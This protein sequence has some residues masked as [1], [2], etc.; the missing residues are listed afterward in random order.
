MHLLFIVICW[1]SRTCRCYLQVS[2]SACKS[3][4]HRSYRCRQPQQLPFASRE[5][6][7]FSQNFQNTPAVLDFLSI[8]PVIV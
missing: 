4:L 6:L 7:H 3:G 1:H 5:P 2:V 8:S